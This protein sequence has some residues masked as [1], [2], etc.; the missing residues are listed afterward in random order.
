MT[1]ATEQ[2]FSARRVQATFLQGW[3]LVEQGHEQAGITQMVRG[4]ASDRAGGG[5]GRWNAHYAALL[6]EAYRKSGR[7]IE[8]LRVVNEELANA[9]VHISGARYYEA[10]VH[11]IKGELLLTQDART[12]NRPKRVFRTR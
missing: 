2:G 8:G 4:L 11:R 5:S 12:S 10:E 7:T 6:A 9:R 1:L 3:L